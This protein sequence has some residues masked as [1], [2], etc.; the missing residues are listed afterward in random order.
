MTI[1]L[2]VMRRSEKIVWPPSSPARASVS[3]SSVVL[4]GGNDCFKRASTRA[5]CRGTRRVLG[6]GLL[7]YIIP[8]F[9]P[10]SEKS[11]KPP[12]GYCRLL[13]LIF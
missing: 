12:S 1:E 8:I 5:T 3:R 7:E 9:P 11:K 10:H 6:L 2:D 4:P 13:P